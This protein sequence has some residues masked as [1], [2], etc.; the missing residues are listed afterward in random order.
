LERVST[1]GDYEVTFYLKRPQPAFLM[2]LAS[3][4]SP[5]Y[6]C[7]VAPAQ[8]RQH[9]IGTGPFKFGEFK[10]NESIKVTR[11]ADYWKKDRPYLDGIEYAVIRNPSTAVLAFISGKFDITFPN[12]L[13]I[14]LKNNI[15]S[16]MP[17][18][19][20]ELTPSAGINRNLI[21]NRD[22]PP[23][24]NPD[25]RRAMAFSL[26]RKA[27]I[28][29][30]TQGQGEMGG[31]MQPAPGGLW[32]LPPDLLRELRAMD[33]MCKKTAHKPARLWRSSATDPT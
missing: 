30:I 1:N 8:M 27:F 19:I 10:P 16:Q 29:I 18:A 32:G 25:L 23:F 11:N 4:N 6:P 2:L 15:E 20:C 24:D 9:P 13:T 14:P 21:V 12:D 31:V 22:V 26:D 33:P 7:H 3:G 17:Q 5:I 28:D